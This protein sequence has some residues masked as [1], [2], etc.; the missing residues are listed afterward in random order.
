MAGF[1]GKPNNYASSLFHNYR[2]RNCVD[3]Y[4]TYKDEI[5]K[6]I[7][8]FYQNGQGNF[9]QN[10]I[11][12]RQHIFNR[13]NYLNYY[14]KNYP[15]HG[16]FIKED[17]I[18][19]FI[20][21][22]PELSQ[23]RRQQAQRD[24]KPVPPK[25]PT[26]GHCEKNGPCHGGAVPTKGVGGEA[27]TGPI[28]VSPETIKPGEKESLGKDTS[29]GE[30]GRTR[31]EKVVSNAREGTMHSGSSSI[32][33]VDASETRVG[34]PSSTFELGPTKTQHLSALSLSASSALSSGHGGYSAQ[35]SS[36]AE[37]GAFTVSEGKTSETKNVP[38]Q[39]GNVQHI[40]DNRSYVKAL[41]GR[42]VGDPVQVDTDLAFREPVNGR[43]TGITIIGGVSNGE[44]AHFN[45]LHQKVTGS[46]GDL[47]GV[48]SSR[49]PCSK[50]TGEIN[51]C[52]EEQYDRTHSAANRADVDDTQHIYL[53]GTNIKAPFGQVSNLAASQETQPIGKAAHS[54]HPQLGDVAQFSQPPQSELTDGEVER[55]GELAGGQRGH[56]GAQGHPP[57]Q[58]YSNKGTFLPSIQSLGE[59][60][61]AQFERGKYSS[62]D[63]IFF[64]IAFFKKLQ[65]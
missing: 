16:K 40:R 11:S 42:I 44:G 17:Q 20:K 52:S 37:S 29:Y 13:N 33:H 54:T 61:Q 32:M 48:H 51:Q 10:C 7:N 58:L 2:F 25:H 64:Q 6:K 59:A 22:C 4:Y 3:S 34:H 24:R 35:T 53:H 47:G 1:F 27:K 18:N 62:K 15:L 5:E 45:A 26:V 39:M 43:P 46:R 50:T 14:C 65:Y 49:I 9:C 36:S 12:I 28:I 55:R 21:Q 56:L 41:D 63:V 19:D 23:C 8:E 57:I 60:V 30:D 38:S 31:L